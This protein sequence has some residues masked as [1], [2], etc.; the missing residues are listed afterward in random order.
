MKYCHVDRN[1][2]TFLGVTELVFESVV[3]LFVVMVI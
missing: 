2:F 3:G 1:S